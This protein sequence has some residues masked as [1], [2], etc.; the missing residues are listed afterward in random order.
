MFTRL[1]FVAATLVFAT[2]AVAAAPL[3]M[4][5]EASYDVLTYSAWGRQN[6]LSGAEC[7]GIGPAGHVLLGATHGSF[8]CQVQVGGCPRAP[9]SPG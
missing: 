1:V 3:K 4:A 6:N 8:R 2:A 7:T 9:S 5:D